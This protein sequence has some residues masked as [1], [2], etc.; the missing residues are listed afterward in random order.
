MGMLFST[1]LFLLVFTVSPLIGQGPEGLEA[2]LPPEVVEHGFADLILVNGKIVSMDD[3]GNND[4]PGSIYQAMAVK[5]RRILALGTDDRIQ[6]LTSSATEVI[7][8]DGRMVIPGIIETHAHIYGVERWAEELGIQLP[9]RIAIPEGATVE[10]TRRNIREAVEKVAVDLEPGAWIVGGMV[11]DPKTGARRSNT[12]GRMGVLAHREFLDGITN[13]HLVLIRAGTRGVINSAALEEANRIMPGYTEFINE[14]MGRGEGFAALIGQVGSQEMSALTWEIFLRGESIEKLAEAIRRNLERA[15][16]QG[17]T[18]FSTRIPMP[19]IMSAFVYLDR[20]GLMPIRLGAHFETHRRAAPPEFTRSF[21]RQ[22]GNLTGLGSD[23]FWL[24]GV[25][26][27]RWDS[28]TVDACL[29]P[30][31]ETASADIKKWELCPEPG[32]LWWD[33]LSAATAAGWRPAGVHGVGSHGVRLF[34]QMLEAV[35]AEMGWT[36]EDIR[37]LRPTVEHADVIGVKPDVLAGLRKYGII[38]SAR[39]GASRTARE[40]MEFYGPELEEYVLPVKTMLNEGIR[41]VGQGSHNNVGRQFWQLVTRKGDARL[42]PSEAIDR[43]RALKMWT[44]WAA[45]YVMRED[46][47]GSLEEG[48]LA[49]FVVLDSDYFTIPV[50]DIPAIVPLMTAV[51]GKTVFLHRRLA[52]ETGREPVG[53]HD[54]EPR[55]W[56]QVGT[57]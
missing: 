40:L 48:K 32:T 50:D 21:Y 37:R 25:A 34:I 51:G 3:V 42:N 17:W 26:S 12:W 22:T 52:Q 43:V 39:G 16:A 1:L 46:D 14:S 49:D 4:N 13:R 29:G 24:T 28:N 30:D 57:R 18:T 15:A 36:V 8:L 35:R 9:T 31:L 41:V 7:D 45:E 2:S 5:R 54:E 55:P 38:V 56:D 20:N 47:L 27:E 19:T 33:V 44:R 11:P 53:Y 6:G 23:Y 10:E